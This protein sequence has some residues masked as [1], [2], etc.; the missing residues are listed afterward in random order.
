[1]ISDQSGRAVGRREPWHRSAMSVS[2]KVPRFS[3]AHT[4]FESP[5]FAGRARTG[6]DGRGRADRLSVGFQEEKVDPNGPA[7]TPVEDPVAE[8][9]G[10]EPTV[11]C[12]TTVFETV[13]IDHSGTSPQEGRVEG[14]EPLT[15]RTVLAKRGLHLEDATLN[16]SHDSFP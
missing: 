6:T 14:A 3:T 11:P 9:V 8:R 7:G 2:R 15:H 1:M 5:N 16:Y 10:F 4:T 12:G 13:P